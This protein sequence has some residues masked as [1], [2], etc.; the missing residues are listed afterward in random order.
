MRNGSFFALCLGRRD[1]MRQFYQ[2]LSLRA[3]IDQCRYRV[4]AHEPE[5]GRILEM[6][7]EGLVAA[8]A[9]VVISADC[10]VRIEFSDCT[11]H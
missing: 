5:K 6:M 11:K 7:R 4:V 1:E 8:R 3:S 9:V 2:S 10:T